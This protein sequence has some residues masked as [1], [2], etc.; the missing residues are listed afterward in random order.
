MSYKPIS[1]TSRVTVRFRFWGK[2]AWCP[3]HPNLLHPLHTPPLPPTLLLGLGRAKSVLR[4]VK[5]TGQ[6]PGSDGG[7]PKRHKWIAL[8]VKPG[9]LRCFEANEKLRQIAKALGISLE[10]FR[11]A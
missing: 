9:G 4:A 5:M 1:G 8:D 3:S 10:V 6:K 11:T 2:P 7:S